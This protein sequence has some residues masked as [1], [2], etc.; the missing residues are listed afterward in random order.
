MTAGCPFCARI[1]GGDVD[2]LVDGIA[3]FPPL[4]PVRRGRHMLYV[5][6]EHIEIDLHEPVFT[7]EL[8]EAAARATRVAL[9]HT[10]AGSCN[11]IWDFGADASQTVPHPHL[12]VVRR[13]RWDCLRLPWNSLW[14]RAHRVLAHLA[15]T[16]GV[17][18]GLVQMDR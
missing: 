5:P 7:A 18:L 8:A 17:H 2:G 6:V 12:H 9:T 14:R 1:A 10:A 11:L 3:W 4:G 13:R 16:V 15:V